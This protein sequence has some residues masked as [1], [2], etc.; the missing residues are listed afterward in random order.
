MLCNLCQTACIQTS[1]AVSSGNKH[2][3]MF[4]F[5]VSWFMSIRDLLLKKAEN[6]FSQYISTCIQYE[7]NSV[8]YFQEWMLQLDILCVYAIEILKETVFRSDDPLLI[9]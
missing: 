4:Y 1:M 5:P 6:I 9:Q 3:V 8:R 2:H 7:S